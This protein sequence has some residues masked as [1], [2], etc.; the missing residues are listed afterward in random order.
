MASY[1]LK[2]KSLKFVLRIVNHSAVF[3]GTHSIGHWLVVISVE[4]GKFTH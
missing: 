2:N 4:K 1:I 3:N